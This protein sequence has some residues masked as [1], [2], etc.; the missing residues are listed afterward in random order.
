[1]EGRHLLQALHCHVRQGS[2]N[3]LK[4]LLF[5]LGLQS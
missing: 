3:W 2:S 5:F 4:K 1:V